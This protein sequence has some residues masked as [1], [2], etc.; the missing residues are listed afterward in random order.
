MSTKAD[1]VGWGRFAPEVRECQRE[2]ESQEYRADSFFAG[3]R[4]LMA[5]RRPASTNR[6]TVIVFVISVFFVF[7]VLVFATSR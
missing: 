5:G 6:H 1:A 3:I 4:E 2:N 7:K